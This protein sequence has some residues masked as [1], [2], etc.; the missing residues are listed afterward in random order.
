MIYLK[1]TNVED[2]KE[3]FK[4]IAQMPEDENGFTNPDA[5]INFEEYVN[6]V[7]PRYKKFQGRGFA[8]GLCA[9]DRLFPMGR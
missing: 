6:N 8:R 4:M 1:E 3:E 7:I 5:G 9:T 2:A